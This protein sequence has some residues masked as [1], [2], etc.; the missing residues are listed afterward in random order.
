M[1][2]SE[3]FNVFLVDIGFSCV[4]LLLKTICFMRLDI[5][6]QL[7]ARKGDRVSSFW[8]LRHS[9]EGIISWGCL[10]RVTS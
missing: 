10:K 6:F 5:C 2:E 4:F 1:F 8:L 3:Y 9:F 7:L